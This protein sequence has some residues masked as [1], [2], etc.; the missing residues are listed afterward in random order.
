[1]FKINLLVLPLL[2]ILLTSCEDEGDDSLVT[3]TPAP[4]EP[5]AILAKSQISFSTG[6]EI[7]RVD[8]NPPWSPIKFT[9]SND[10]NDPIT[11]VAIS[12]E[13]TDPIEGETL[14]VTPVN[15][16]LSDSVVLSTV[17]S[18]AD[19]NCDGVV[20]EDDEIESEIIPPGSDLVNCSL[21]ATNLNYSDRALYIE[22][23]VQNTGQ[24]STTIA[25]Q[26]RGLSFQVVGRFEGWYGMPE[27]PLR[28]FFKEV[29]FT[30][31]AN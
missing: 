26:Y 13:V 7:I 27:Q 5:L 15:F 14:V 21:D 9:V 22:S 28:N 24:N 3:I 20:D 17:R 1:M 2:F 25:N 31:K 19:L 16:T 12:F 29:F 6:L 8:L 30:L 23:V 4:S 11:I 10:S 18:N